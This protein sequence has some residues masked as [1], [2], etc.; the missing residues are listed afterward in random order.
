MS[1][2][3]QKFG[4]SSVADAAGIERVAR[5]VA[6]TVRA[7]NRVCVVVSAMAA[8]AVVLTDHGR[9]VQHPEQGFTWRT[10]AGARP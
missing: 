4:G 3:V 1:L 8:D 9:R 10:R 5:R 6:D 7:G 2:I